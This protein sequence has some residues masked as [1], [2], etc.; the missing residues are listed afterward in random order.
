MGVRNN[1]EILAEWSSEPAPLLPILHAF[2][3]RDGYLSED[4]LRAISDALKIP[5][6]DL[7]GT[8]SFYHHFSGDPGGREAP[9]VCT[10]PVCVH[11]GSLGL[12]AELLDKGGHAMPCAGRCDDPIPVLA[13]SKALTG[14][15]AGSL[16]AR[17]SPLPAPPPEGIQECVFAHLRQRSG[18]GLTAY[19]A[20]ASK[21]INEFSS[22]LPARL[23]VADTRMLALTPA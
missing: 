5:L 21:L 23:A 8:V 6:A 3:D 9:R 14:L 15:D 22:T 2:H 7:Y 12:L 16:E 10:G 20:T 13:G 19:R 11:K 1:E 4:S 17:P 18:K